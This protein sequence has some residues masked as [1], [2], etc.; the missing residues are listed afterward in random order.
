MVHLPLHKV[1]VQ[2][3]EKHIQ[4]MAFALKT[5]QYAR[6]YTVHIYTVYFTN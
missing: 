4:Y 1:Q 5:L 3:L 2:Y 6:A